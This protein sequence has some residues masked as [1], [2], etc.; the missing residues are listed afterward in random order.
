MSCKVL[1]CFKFL[2]ICYCCCCGYCSAANLVFG[3]IQSH[4]NPEEAAVIWIKYAQP[5]TQPAIR[6]SGKGQGAA[7]TR[8]LVNVNSYWLLVESSARE[9]CLET[10]DL[11][12]CLLQKQPT[13]GV[14]W[15]FKRRS[16]DKALSLASAST[17]SFSFFCSC[18]PTAFAAVALH[19]ELLQL[20]P[21]L[22]Y[23]NVSDN[24]GSLTTQSFNISW[25][26]LPATTLFRS[27]FDIICNLNIFYYLIWLHI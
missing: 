19:I 21:C 18:F 13:L 22:A 26:N 7:A 10:V 1:N 25:N 4:I 3:S 20:L 12:G 6:G 11:R 9:A 23:E 16:S 27:L 2:F 24:W 15:N 14:D 5:Q 17:S 8:Y